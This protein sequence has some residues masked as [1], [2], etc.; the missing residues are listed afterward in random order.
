MCVFCRKAYH[1]AI[2]PH[3]GSGASIAAQSGHAREFRPTLVPAHAFTIRLKRAKGRAM[4]VQ[5]ES[6]GFFNLHTFAEVQTE[7]TIRSHMTID[8]GRECPEILLSHLAEVPGL[9]Q[10]ALNQ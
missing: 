7:G 4:S 9:C 2:T 6:C 3:C 8:E 1:L 10:N 5:H